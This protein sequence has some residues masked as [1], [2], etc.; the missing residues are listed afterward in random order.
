MSIFIDMSYLEM[1]CY[2]LFMICF[3]GA[4]LI[5]YVL[6]A[7]K[8]ID[9]TKIK[10]D[11]IRELLRKSLGYKLASTADK[12]RF[13][14]VRLIVLGVFIRIYP[15]LISWIKSSVLQFIQ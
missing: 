2:V 1:F 7:N 12:D 4:V 15:V 11:D 9:T 14:I 8:C 3:I 10:N 5:C 6:L 13:V